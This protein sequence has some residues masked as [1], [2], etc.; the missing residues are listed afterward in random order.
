MPRDRPR[1][2]ATLAGA[3]GA[4]GRMPSVDE[5]EEILAQLP[6]PMGSIVV[7]F[8]TLVRGARQIVDRVD[9]WQRLSQRRAE[10]GQAPPPSQFG[11]D[12]LNVWQEPTMQDKRAVTIVAGMRQ[13]T[14]EAVDNPLRVTL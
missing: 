14:A 9:Q 11:G 10:R 12:R 6:K 7:V 1:S 3:N 13:V 8:L 2:G 4:P 5:S